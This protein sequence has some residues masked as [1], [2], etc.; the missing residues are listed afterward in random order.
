MDLI[1][2]GDRRE[3][4][5]EGREACMRGVPVEAVDGEGC[6]RPRYE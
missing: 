3:R 5:R 1:T 6:G 4:P 2:E